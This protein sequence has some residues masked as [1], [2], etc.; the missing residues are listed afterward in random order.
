MVRPVIAEYTDK[1]H[2]LKPNKWYSIEIEAKDG[3]TTYSMNGRK[4][5]E[6]DADRA[7]T[8]GYFGLRLL[9]NHCLIRDFK[10]ESI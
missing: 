10:I 5:F 4:L 3:H 9:S 6:L 2:L 7:D 1:A 8:D